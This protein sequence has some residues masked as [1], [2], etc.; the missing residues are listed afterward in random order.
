MKLMPDSVRHDDWL[1]QNLETGTRIGY[2]PKL[3]EFG[4]LI[5]FL[6]FINLHQFQ[7]RPVLSSRSWPILTFNR[8]QLPATWWTW[9]GLI[10]LWRH[11]TK[12]FIWRLRNAAKSRPRSWLECEANW[13]SANAT[14][15]CLANSMTSLVG[16]PLFF[17]HSKIWHSRALQFAWLRH[18]FQPGVL[19]LCF[20]HCQWE[21]K[22]P[23]PILSFG[24]PFDSHFQIQ[25]Y[26]FVDLRKLSP[27]IAAHLKKN[28]IDI[29]DYKDVTGFI[30]QYHEAC[31]NGPQPE[32]HKVT[33]IFKYETY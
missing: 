11:S 31:K 3:F 24:C 16:F 9:F 10:S 27:E 17:F 26:L 15:F 18:S 28:G 2:D 32:K 33:A 1:F 14:P 6:L 22:L 20:C 21:G 7:R 8:C 12:L 23:L 5:Y 4:S 19:F 30:K 25:A 13:P 29:F